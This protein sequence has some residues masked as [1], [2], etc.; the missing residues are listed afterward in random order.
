MCWVGLLMSNRMLTASIDL[1]GV[2]PS[3]FLHTSLERMVGSFQGTPHAFSMW[4]NLKHRE[5]VT[6]ICR[7]SDVIINA[8]ASQ[9]TGVSI[10]CWAVSLGADQRKHQSFGSL[11]FVRGIRR[12]P[13]NS[14]HKGPGTRKMFPFDDVIMDPKLAGFCGCCNIGNTPKCISNIAKSRLS[15]TY[16]SVVNSFCNFA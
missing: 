9:I 15:I 14:P 6:N 8:M 4:G 12:W 10:V 7:Y 16:W 13:V 5:P 3:N 1:H 11:A 2:M